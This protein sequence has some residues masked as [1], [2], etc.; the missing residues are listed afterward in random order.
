M[1]PIDP[2]RLG[3]VG[4]GWVSESYFES[5]AMH[6]EVQV[7]ACADVDRVAAER[8]AEKFGVP[9]V[10]DT[11]ALLTDPEVEMVVNLTP[12]VEHAEITMAA[13]AA[14]KHVYTEKPIAETLAV[15]EEIIAAA[16]AAKVGL[17]SA[18]ATF[19]G[20][21][22]QTSLK[23]LDDGWIGTP[24][25]ATAMISTRGIERWHPYP[26]QFYGPGGGS[27]LDLGP[28]VIT[29][30]VSFFGPVR[31]V[32]AS[33][34]SHSKTRPRFNGP[35]GAPD[36]PVVAAMHAAGIVD[37]VSGPAA[38]VITS[39]EMWASRLP[40]MEVY[41]SEGTISTPD[42]DAFDGMPSLRRAEA[43]DLITMH[44]PGAGDW[45]DIPLTHRGDVGRGIAIADMADGLRTGRPFRADAELAYHVLEV[46]LAFDQSSERG[47]H[48]EIRS[49]CSRPAPLPTVA[50]EDRV[51]FAA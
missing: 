28:Y 9:R 44:T 18:P 16:K 31:R 47:E 41:G 50:G 25:A 20:G 34:L 38:T 6:P 49:T 14:G 43:R 12:A 7:V 8:Q 30:L 37:F 45:H 51:R 4:C 48:V 19:L 2:M 22:L 17:G 33:T 15:A 1:S 11:E 3:V 5:C 35:A 40:H 39:F 46:M 42:P 36:I 32:A 23:L 29:A 27:M 24:F 13:I 21:G 10:L 26:D